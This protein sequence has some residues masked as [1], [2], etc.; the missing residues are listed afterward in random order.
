MSVRAI[1]PA[2]VVRPGPSGASAASRLHLGVTLT[3]FDPA[4]HGATKPHPTAIAPRGAAKKKD[5]KVE[6]GE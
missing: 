1:V 5:K 2:S 4:P 3:R 6:K